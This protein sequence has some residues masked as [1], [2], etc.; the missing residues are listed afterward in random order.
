MIEAT[1]NPEDNKLRLRSDSRI[2][3]TTFA[4]ARALGFMWAPKQELLVAP[5]WTPER[6]DFALSVADD[7]EI[8]PD[9]ETTEDRAAARAERF[10]TYS[11]KRAVDAAAAE[12]QFHRIADGIP[13]GQ[14]ILVGHHSERR[15]RKDQQRI[16]AAADRAHK[17]WQTS[18]YWKRRAADLVR[19][20]ARMDSPGVRARR[21]KTLQADARRHER[22]IKEAAS[23]IHNWRLV[24]DGID[25]P[26]AKNPEASPQ[27]MMIR[28]HKRAR[29]VANFDYLSRCY[30]LAEFPRERPASQ[31]EG[32]LGLWSAL[33]DTPEE[34]II[35][36]TQAATWAI[37]QHTARLARENRCLDHVRQRIEYE[38]EVLAS[39]GYTPPEKPKRPALA[40][41]LNVDAAEIECRN[42][43]QDRTDTLPV[44]KMTAAEYAA[45]YRDYKG[46]YLT[47]KGFRVRTTI[48]APG[49]KIHGT[50]AV[51]LTDSKAHTPPTQ[52]TA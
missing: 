40:P 17:N 27:E 8:H 11:E 15:A 48:H 33:G 18:E 37:E 26:S 35:T 43:Y 21:I 42:Q 44:V 22:S 3:Q 2:D 31:Y 49:Q 32:A 6:E 23:H 36:P 50:V 45:I 25:V 41:L 51:F 47:T 29:H 12:N 38:T 52:A 13:L 20:A 39:Q 16:Q 4:A 5:A 14:P 19:H 46:T 7:G 24:F 34:A 10:A 30:T 28:D 9:D 1:Y